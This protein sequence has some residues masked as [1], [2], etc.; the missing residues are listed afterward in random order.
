[1][2]WS[3]EVT[4]SCFHIPVAVPLA[5]FLGWLSR[6]MCLVG[7]LRAFAN[8]TVLVRPTGMRFC[9]LH[10]F[11]LLSLLKGRG[12]L[13]E[14]LVADYYPHCLHSAWTLCPPSGERGLFAYGSRVCS[15]ALLLL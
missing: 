6:A 13:V 10:S 1:M 5:S 8:Q 11:T 12:D 9:V 7:D 2:C 3:T 15:R 4:W 14:R